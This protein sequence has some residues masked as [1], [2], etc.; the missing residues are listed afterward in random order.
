MTVLLQVLLVF[1]CAAL[2]LWLRVKQRNLHRVRQEQ[3][4][5][6]GERDALLQFVN[7]AG[8]AFAASGDLELDELLSRVAFM[9]RTATGAGAAS[10][11]MYDEQDRCFYARAIDGPAP[12]LVPLPDNATVSADSTD[13]QLED[14]VFDT[15]IRGEEGL[16]REVIE[17]GEPLWVTQAAADPRVPTFP[18]ESRRIHNLILAPMRFQSEVK[19]I[20]VVANSEKPQ[21]FVE[22]D[23][24][25]LQALADQTAISMHFGG[26]NEALQQKQLMDYDLD[27]ARQIQRSLLPEDIPMVPRVQLAA[28]NHPARQVGGDYYDFIQL[29]EKHLGIA[30][31][32]VSGKGVAGAMMMAIC[33]S[34][35]RA[36]ASGVYSPAQVVKALNAVMSLDITEDMFVTLIYMVLNIDTRELVVARAGH[37]PPIVCTKNL[38]IRHIESSGVAIGIGSPD[39]MEETLEET[40]VQLNAGDLVV[41]YTD[42]VT[43]AQ[44]SQGE[45]WGLDRFLETIK[46]TAAEGAFRVLQAVNQE[47]S[48]FVGEAPQYDDTTLLVL[49][50]M[51]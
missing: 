24:Y 13:I 23:M 44:S 28:M 10:L 36:Q 47:Q 25:L 16:F 11:H 37:E 42:G 18:I 4:R 40:R 22:L 14:L 38:A 12:L 51:E 20:L 34:V 32:D 15:P 33:R 30:I 31:A 35:L 7:D 41:A 9:A 27:V 1:T 3:Q 5:I 43:E 2:A 48:K 19:G 50:I 45:E 49:K 21:G 26:L 39:T 6:A 17:R 8:K 29:D 46:A